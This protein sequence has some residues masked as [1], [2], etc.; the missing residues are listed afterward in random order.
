MGLG[1]GARRIQGLR[2]PGGLCKGY[3]GWEDQEVQYRARSHGHEPRV[4]RA[5]AECHIVPVQRSVCWGQQVAM[6]TH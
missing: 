4:W 3:I 6:N 1:F 2:G 5:D